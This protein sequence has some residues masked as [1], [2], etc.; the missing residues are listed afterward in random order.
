MHILESDSL[1]TQRNPGT[2]LRTENLFFQFSSIQS[3]WFMTCNDWAIDFLFVLS[4]MALGDTNWGILD[5]DDP[6]CPLWVAA[7]LNNHAYY[8]SSA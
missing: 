2:Y 1:T 3:I 7:M 5:K 4:R 8:R 6:V